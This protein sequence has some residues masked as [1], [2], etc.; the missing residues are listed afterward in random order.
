MNYSKEHIIKKHKELVSTGRKFSTKVLV[1][2][3]RLLMLAILLAGA[4]G[5]SVGFGAVTGIL[6]GTPEATE[7]SIAPSGVSTTVYDCDGNVIEKLVGSGSNRIPVSIDQIPE[8]LKYAFVDIEDE[9][10][11]SH[12]GIDVK[13]ILRAASSVLQGDMQGASTITQQLLKNNVFINGGFENSMGELVKRKLQEQYLALELEKIQ[14]KN[15][16]LENYLNTIN[17]G[18]GSYGVQAAAKRYFDKDVSE[19]TISESAVISSITQNPNGSKGYNPIHHPE[20]NQRRRA[21]VLENMLKNGHLTQEEYDIAVADTED[22]YKRI[23]VV[24]NQV[25][26]DNSP[27]TYFVDELISQ[28]LA[29]LQE[30]K[31]YTYEQASSLLYS[32]GLSIYATQDSE[33]QAICDEETSNPDNY[34]G[35]IYYSFDWRWSVQSRWK[36]RAFIKCGFNLL[37]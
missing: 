36:C 13:G 21:K 22:V 23:Q 25:E 27:Y 3:F 14:S 32:G 31:G 19:L 2:I 28:V 5:V 33:I 4:V 15:V 29:D 16:I 12:N 24:N 20:N 11:Y 1:N 37:Q 10:F 34:P 35:K 18:S 6:E 8:H 7:I 17:L 9:R 30:Q 26:E